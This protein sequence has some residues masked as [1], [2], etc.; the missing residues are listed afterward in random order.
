VQQYS[1]HI[2]VAT[3][4]HEHPCHKNVEQQTQ[5]RYH[6][7]RFTV[8]NNWICEPGHELDDDACHY[9]EHK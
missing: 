2:E 8:D 1:P 6:R 7:Y 9:H 4:M 3:S 5:R